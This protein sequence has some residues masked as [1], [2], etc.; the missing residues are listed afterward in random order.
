MTNGFLNGFYFRFGT[1][2]SSKTANLL[3][4]AYNYRSRNKKIVIMKPSVDVRMSKTKIVSRAVPAME[5]TEI[6][7]PHTADFSHISTDVKCVL[8]DEAQFLS[9]EN[10]DA[11]RTLSI[12]VPVICYGLRTDYRGKLFNGSKRL[13]EIVDTIEDISTVCD[14]CD[15][16]AIINA[17]FGVDHKGKKHIINEGSGAPDLGAEEKYMP[18]CWVCWRN[19]NPPAIF[20]SRT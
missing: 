10:V 14:L 15:G 8:V 6:I 16:K 11:L 1:M 2:N 13:F 9:D 18:L 5:A 7:Q 4:V 12:R 17:K 20:Y 3:M 19:P